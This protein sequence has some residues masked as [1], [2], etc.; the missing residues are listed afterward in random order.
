MDARAR[1]AKEIPTPNRGGFRLAPVG[2]Q[3]GASQGSVWRQT[4]VGL[5]PVESWSGAGR[6]FNLHRLEV[7]PRQVGGPT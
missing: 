1:K 5:A 6:G 3:S 4:E 2:V 7:K